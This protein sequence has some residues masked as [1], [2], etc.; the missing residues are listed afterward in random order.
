MNRN[1]RNGMD[2]SHS[3]EF[4]SLEAYEAYSDYNGMA[5]LTRD[6]PAGRP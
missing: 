3:P 6:H 1:F 4:T 2:S 5:D